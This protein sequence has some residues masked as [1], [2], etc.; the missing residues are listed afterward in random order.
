[1]NA[2]YILTVISDDKPGIV[3]QIA[4]TV[5]KHGGN[6]LESRLTQLAGKFA[7]VIRIAVS[8]Q[9]SD[10]LRAALAELSAGHIHIDMEAV[11]GA[12]PR[13]PARMANFSA[14]G[15]DRPGIVF[16]IAQAFTHYGI[17]VVEL[18]TDCS[19][20]PY[21]GEPLFE[22][23]GTIALPEDTDWEQLIDQLE[24]IADTLGVDVQLHEYKAE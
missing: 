16:E 20:M 15:P 12:K 10:A 8:E 21:S 2:H 11:S 14:A 18:A 19:S 24:A 13:P 22:A 5:S 7:G 23:E 9:Q 3:K 1:M 4:N 17:S 6:W